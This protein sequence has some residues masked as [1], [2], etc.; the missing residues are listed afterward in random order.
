MLIQMVETELEKKK[1]EEGTY[2]REFMGKSHFF[3]YLISLK[4]IF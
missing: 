4:C 2:K 3:G 1:T